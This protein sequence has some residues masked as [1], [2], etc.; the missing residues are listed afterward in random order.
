MVEVRICASPGRDST[1]K[2]SSSNQKNSRN[3]EKQNSNEPSSSTD[4]ITPVQLVSSHSPGES[5]TT[6]YPRASVLMSTSKDPSSAPEPFQF[7]SAQVQAKK[8]REL[9]DSV[10]K[11]LLL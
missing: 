7:P 10:H 3:T 5:P 8:R 6:A 11:L 1:E 9:L 4:I 2:E